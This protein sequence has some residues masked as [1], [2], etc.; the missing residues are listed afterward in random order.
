MCP[1]YNPIICGLLE[2]LVGMA[3]LP[4]HQT[5]PSQQGFSLID[6]CSSPEGQPQKLL[7]PSAWQP[8]NYHLTYLKTM[9]ITSWNLLYKASMPNSIRFIREYDLESSC[10]PGP[11]LPCATWDLKVRRPELNPILVLLWYSTS[12][13]TARKYGSTVLLIHVQHSAKHL[14]LCWELPLSGHAFR[15]LC[16]YRW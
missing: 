15:L 1:H 13:C 11:L 8:F 14:H 9:L 6:L 16:L 4:L 5:L 12:N 2:L 3:F 7:N 10:Y